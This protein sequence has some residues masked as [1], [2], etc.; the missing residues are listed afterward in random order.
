MRP[1][2]PGGPGAVV[3]KEEMEVVLAWRLPWT[4]ELPDTKEFCRCVHQPPEVVDAYS[5]VW[6]TGLVCPCSCVAS[7]KMLSLSGP[8]C[9]CL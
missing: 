7:R 1:W 3:G 5:A 9:G 8:Q 2:S 4:P 6:V